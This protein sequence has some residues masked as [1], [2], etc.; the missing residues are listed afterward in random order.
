[1]TRCW[2]LSA[3][4]ASGYTS[5]YSASARATNGIGAAAV[6]A[7]P[8]AALLVPPLLGAGGGAPELLVAVAGAAADCGT[9]ALLGVVAAATTTLVGARALVGLAEDGGTAEALVAADVAVVVPAVALAAAG[10][11]EATNTDVEYTTHVFQYAHTQASNQ[12]FIQHHL[13]RCAPTTMTTT[14]TTTTGMCHVPFSRCDTT[15]ADAR[16][17]AALS[18]RIGGALI[19]V[20]SAV[21][22]STM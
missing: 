8:R 14:T 19:L 10:L 13:A 21:M 5:R 12:P 3:L 17:L 22:A 4:A 16:S 20:P 6:A 2:Y 11:G 15:N 9:F 7:L 1:M 18:L